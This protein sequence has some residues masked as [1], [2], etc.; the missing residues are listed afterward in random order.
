MA[1]VT[2]GTNIG[3]ALNTYLTAG[4]GP[5]SKLNTANQLTAAAASAAAAVNPL[6]APMAITAGYVAMQSGISALSNPT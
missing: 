1:L 4:S 6:A 3:G 2:Q 5:L